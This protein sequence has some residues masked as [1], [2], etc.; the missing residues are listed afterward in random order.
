MSGYAKKQKGKRPGEVFGG[1]VL[2]QFFMLSFEKF[3]FT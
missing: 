2:H 3:F 1:N